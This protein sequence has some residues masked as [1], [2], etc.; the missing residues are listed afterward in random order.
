MNPAVDSGLL[1]EVIEGRHTEDLIRQRKDYNDLR[2]RMAY[3]YICGSFPTHLRIWFTK[4]ITM[5]TGRSR[6]PSALD[7]AGGAIKVNPD[8]VEKLAL[9]QHPMVQA[10]RGYIREGWKIARQRQ[11]YTDRRPYSRIFLYRKIKTF[12]GIVEEK[13]TIYINGAE[14]DGWH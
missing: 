1:D 3:V 4:L 7:K 2:D 14:R 11:D 5:A 10:V 12:R 9:E 6:E 13:K 8:V